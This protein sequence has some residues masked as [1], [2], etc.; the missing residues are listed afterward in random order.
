MCIDNQ[1]GQSLK[2]NLMCWRASMWL[3]SVRPGSSKAS[4]LALS[5]VGE[6]EQIFHLL[7]QRCPNMISMRLRER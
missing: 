6:I 5:R 3:Q 7:A 2:I 1:S 4:Y